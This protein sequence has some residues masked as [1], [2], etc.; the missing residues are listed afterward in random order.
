MS[1]IP[2][3]YGSMTYHRVAR[4]VSITASSLDRDDGEYNKNSVEK[5]V[6]DA[7]ESGGVNERGVVVVVTA[8]TS[9]LPVAEEVAVVLEASFAISPFGN[10]DDHY[11]TD[12]TTIKINKNRKSNS[13]SSNQVTPIMD[14]LRIN[15]V[16]IAGL[17][18]LLSILP[19]LSHPSV[20]C[21]V[22]CAGMDGALPGV[23]AGLINAPVIAVPTSRGGY[24][25][26]VGG[27]AAMMT[28]LNACAPG[29][30]VVN[31]DNGF[32]GAALAYKIVMAGNGGG[33]D[34]GGRLV[35]YRYV[36][37]LST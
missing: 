32:G 28:M 36:H 11:L 35:V 6:G 22:V 21:V 31:V 8:G 5:Y 12:K 20:R 7:N 3:I 15:D 25:C 2:L 18:R 14:V 30:G 33:N 13:N 4:I 27:I 37:A 19:S 9:D 23:V 29:V 17:H 1:S 34:G 16:G 10:G 24:G 26:G